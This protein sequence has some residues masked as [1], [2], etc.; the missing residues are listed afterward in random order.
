LVFLF[1][2]H[3]SWY[4]IYQNNPLFPLRCDVRGYKVQRKTL[5]TATLIDLVICL[6]SISLSGYIELLH[7]PGIIVLV[8]DVFTYFI[9]QFIPIAQI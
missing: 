5:I 7:F 3:S 9:T 6:L 2:L 1:Y 4:V 8:M